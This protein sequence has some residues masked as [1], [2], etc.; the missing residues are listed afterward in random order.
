M[1]VSRR[2]AKV[3][4]DAA[5]AVGMLV[6]LAACGNSSANGS[7]DSNGVTTIEWWG[8]DQGQKEQADAFNKSQDKIKV[9]YKKQASNTKA[10]ESLVNTVKA[11]S[12]VPDLF[13]ADMDSTIS[14]LADG[15]IQDV[16]QYKPDLSKLNPNVVNSFKV[17]DQLAVIPYKSSPQFMIANQKTFDDNGVKV[18]TTWDEFIQAGKDLKA[19]NPNIKIFNMAGEDPAMLVLTAQQFGAKWYQV[20]GDKWVIDI[21]G[22]ESKKAVNY[23]QQ[24]VDNDMFSQK[25]FIEWDALMQ[26]FQSGDLAMIGT[27]TWQLSAYQANFQKSLGDWVAVDWPKESADSKLVAPL[28]AQGYAIPKGA[29]NPQAAVTFAT[30]LATDPTALKIAADST[31]GSGAFP[32]LKDS[33]PYVS[34]SLPDKLLKDKPQAE[35]VVKDAADSVAPYSTGV[36]WSSMYKQMQDQWAKFLNKQTT[37]EQ[38]LDYLQKW[39][40]NDLKQ[41]GINAEAA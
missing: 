4:V 31:K 36:N 39:T 11:G 18:P 20:K 35:T 37:G 10:E 24:I 29:K 27:S 23:L 8:Y 40:L 13:E 32:A 38:M 14:L 28:N 33:A 5:A 2:W 22:P 9:V 7:T 26:F 41:K 16:N 34:A 12:G 19:K 15:T 25:T 3:A 6:P 30:W 21:N 17:G 1:N